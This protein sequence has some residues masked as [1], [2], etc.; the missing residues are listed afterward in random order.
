MA[1]VNYKLS[2]DMSRI[3]GNGNVG[4]IKRSLSCSEEEDGF[5]GFDTG[6]LS[7]IKCLFVKRSRREKKSSIFS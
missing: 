2:K 1:S 4:G 6:K 5:L 7:K 3:E